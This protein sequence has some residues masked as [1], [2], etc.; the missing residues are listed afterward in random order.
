L[1]KAKPLTWRKSVA[2]A[3]TKELKAHIDG[4]QQEQDTR[5]GREVVKRF[6]MER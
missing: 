4:L 6:R 1:P 3:A 5:Y 2:E